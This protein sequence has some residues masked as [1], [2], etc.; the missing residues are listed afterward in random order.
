MTPERYAQIRRNFESMLAGPV[1]ERTEALRKE[2][3]ADRDLRDAVEQLLQAH[4]HKLELLDRPV[5]ARIG[6]LPPNWPSAGLTGTIVG[7]Y[8]ICREIGRGGMGAVYLSERQ[9]GRV[10]QRVAVKVV[11]TE[12][13]DRAHLGRRFEQE[14]EI[15]ASFDHANIA[16]FLDVGTTPEGLPYLVMEY[17]QGEPI[18]PG[19]IA[20]P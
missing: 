15:V 18:T 13:H 7:P 19:A 5:S 20:T 8:T 11:H 14:R 1:E 3:G 12:N 9:I 17:V 16:R 10:C 4:E 6:E 2:A